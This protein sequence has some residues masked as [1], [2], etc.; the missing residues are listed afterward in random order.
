MSEV[1]RARR[2]R[3]NARDVVMDASCD[4]IIAIEELGMIV[5]DF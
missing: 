4:D 5:G 3:Q 2:L 1:E